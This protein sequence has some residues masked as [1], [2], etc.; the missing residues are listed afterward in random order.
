MNK[1]TRKSLS[2]SN[3]SNSNFNVCIP[4]WSESNSSEDQ[5]IKYSIKSHVEIVNEEMKGRSS[6][7]EEIGIR[8]CREEVELKL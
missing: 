5:D 4:Q 7:E 8:K 2:T 6:K 3:T 1:T